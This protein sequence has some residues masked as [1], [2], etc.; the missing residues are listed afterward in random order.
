MLTLEDEALAEFKP[1]R[2]WLHNVRNLMLTVFSQSNFYGSTHNIYAELGGFG[3]TAMIIDEDF[4]RIN[5][6]VIRCRPLTIGEF[7]IALDEYYRPCALYRK[8]SNSVEQLVGR[9]GLGNVSPTIKSLYERGNYDNRTDVIHAIEMNRGVDGRYADERGMPLKSCYFEEGAEEDSVLEEKGYASMPFVAPRWLVIGVNT[10]GYCPAMSALADVKMMQTMEQKY[11]KALDKH[12]DPPMNAPS[13]LKRMGGGKTVAGAVN[14]IDVQNGQQTFSPSYQTQPPSQALQMKIDSVERRIRKYFFNDLFLAV[15][16]EEKS[17]TASEVAKRFEEKLIMLSPTLEKLQSEF[18]DVV[19]ERTFDIM[20]RAGMIPPPP[21][22]LRG[23]PI[24]V[25]YI[26]LLAQAQK[27]VGTASI[28]QLLQFMN[29]A[30]PLNPSVADK[31]DLDEAVDQYGTMLGVPPAVIRSD[32]EVAKMRA[33]RQKIEQ[34]KQMAETAVPMANAAKAASQA[35]VGN[36]QSVLQRAF[37]GAV[38]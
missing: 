17:M 3:T 22:E 4:Q 29:L 21:A 16:N 5:P 7:S 23:K 9:F 8:F 35:D 37:Q 10:Y 27:M 34:A 30:I 33:D 32:D 28:E 13:Q 19:I 38:S 36:G 24:K 1:V 18:L 6:K 11:L 20:E 2:M 15:L 14:Y 31:I 26:S 12:V 25:E